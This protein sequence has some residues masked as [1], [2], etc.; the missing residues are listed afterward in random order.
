MKVKILYHV[1]LGD[2][3]S[4]HAF[5]QSL[6]EEMGKRILVLSFTHLSKLRIIIIHFYKSQ[7]SK[8]DIS[9]TITCY[10][11]QYFIS[12]VTF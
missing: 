1:S 10:F 6:R 7:I 3:L 4:P 11:I 8:D 9:I 12:T 5:T 2:S